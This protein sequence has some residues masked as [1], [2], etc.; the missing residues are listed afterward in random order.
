MADLLVI[1]YDDASVRT[2]A[3]ENDVAAPLA[4]NDKPH[5]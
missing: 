4:V 3:P 2:I 5:A 1:R